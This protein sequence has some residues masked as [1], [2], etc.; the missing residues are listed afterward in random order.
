MNS[1]KHEISHYKSIGIATK[2]SYKIGEYIKHKA[3]STLLTGGN[4][5]IPPIANPLINKIRYS[6]TSVEPGKG[7]PIYCDLGFG[8]VEHS[9]IYIGNFEAI[10][11]NGRGL[12]EVVNLFD[13]T[14]N[15]TTTSRDVFFPL[16]KVDSVPIELEEAYD[17]ALCKR[18]K[19]IKY[20]VVFNN[21]HKF[22]SGCLT[23]DFD[24][25]N[26]LLDFMKCTT[27]Q[28]YGKK[29]IWRRWDW[30]SQIVE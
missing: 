27:E 1:K 4:F 29:I 22:T 26:Q 6:S 10:Q 14:D 18:G 7:S 3:V 24:Q 15:V 9:G 30:I 2:V 16:D 20:N 21:C 23:G 28:I 13:F 11:L 25:N 17:N 12:V 19:L 8:F 5:P